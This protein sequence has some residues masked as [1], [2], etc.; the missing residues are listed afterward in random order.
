[1]FGW[2]FPP[3]ISGGLGMACYGIIN[4][5]AKKNQQI[6]FVLPLADYDAPSNHNIS[7]ISCHTATKKITDFSVHPFVDVKKVDALLHPYLNAESYD[8]LLQQYRL[9]KN[10]R[11]NNAVV[12]IA[13]KYGHSLLTEV[14][15]YSLA[16]GSLAE[17]LP[18]DVIHAHDWL[19]VLAGIHAKSISHKPLIFHVHALEFDRCGENVNPDIF[20]IEKHGLE[21]ADKIVAVS[22]FTKNMIMHR[23]GIPEGKIV[24]VHNGIDGGGK[25]PIYVKKPEHKMVLFVGRLTFQKGP[26]YFLKVAEK[27]LSRQKDVHFV[28]AGTGDMMKQ[29][30]EETAKMRI[31]KN[32]HF[33]GFLNQDTIKKLYRLADVYVMPS[34]SEPFGLTCLEALSGNVPVVISKQSGVKEVLGPHVL[35]A[36]FWDINEMAAKVLALLTYPSLKKEIMSNAIN[37]IKSVT[38]EDTANKLIALYSDLTKNKE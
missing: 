20:A 25:K 24:V 31:G 6:S 11:S 1:M 33:T 27:I 34:V 5:L 29:M 30:I 13:G 23:Y 7:L 38:W 9:N 8:E 28:I 37:Q 35:T 12:N 21:Q 4:E 18:H 14:Y 17:T 36:D 3:H 15:R 16:A 22:Q 32:V 19:T 26:D 2:E 10:D